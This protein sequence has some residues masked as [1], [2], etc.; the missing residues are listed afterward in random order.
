M[1]QSKRKKRTTTETQIVTR[2]DTRRVKQTLYYV[3][4]T[5][6]SS[7]HRAHCFFYGKLFDFL[8]FF[9]SINLI[10]STQ[11]SLMSQQYT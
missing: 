11:L 7:S 8:S 3:K 2:Y 1:L 10:L 9:E 5:S 4:F 6:Y